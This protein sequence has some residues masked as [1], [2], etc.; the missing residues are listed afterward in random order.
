VWP[1]RQATE[2]LVLEV[3]PLKVSEVLV[4]QPNGGGAFA[5]G[6]GDSLH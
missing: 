2:E 4:D 1:P 5:D 3:V 6:G